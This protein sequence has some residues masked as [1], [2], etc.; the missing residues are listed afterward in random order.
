M[1]FQRKTIKEIQEDLE[2]GTPSP[3]QLADYRVQIAGSYGRLTDDL[4][5]IHAV[6]MEPGIRKDQI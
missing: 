6:K 5:E 1:Q 2:N 4:I 3:H